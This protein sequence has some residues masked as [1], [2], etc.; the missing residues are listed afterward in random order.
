SLTDPPEIVRDPAYAKAAT[1]SDRFLTAELHC[2]ISALPKPTVQWFKGSDELPLITKYRTVL[3]DLPSTSS[4]QLL[5]T[6]DSVLFIAN[7]TKED[8]GIYL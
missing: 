3:N 2:R 1:D 5:F 8:H 7:V 4:P 6:Y